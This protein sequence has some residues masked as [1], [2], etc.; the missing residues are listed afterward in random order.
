MKRI[1]PMQNTVQPYPWGS[2]TAIAEL[3]GRKTPAL[4]PQAELWMGAHP[5]APSLVACEEQWV[6][7]IDLIEKA[8]VDILGES[9]IQ[10]F[11]K[12]LPYLFK[13]LA[14]ARPLS[15][16]A[17]PN[18]A[19]A[20]A[21]FERE[22]RCGLALDAPD[23][24]YRDANHKPECI[25]ALTPFWALNGF[26]PMIDI[27]AYLRA[28]CPHG[29]AAERAALQQLPNAQG[30]AR[31]IK[32]LLSMPPSRKKTV[33]DETRQNAASL[34]ATDKIYTWIETLCRAYP[35]DIGVL[36][37]VFL[38][39]LKLEPGQAMFLHSGEMHAYLYGVG[40]ELM[41]NS[42]NVLR[43][44]LTAKHVDVRELLNI[45][46]F[47]P[48]QVEILSGVRIRP[49]EHA[50]PCPAQEFVLSVIST[51]EDRVYQSPKGRGVEI[52]L[53][54]EGQA[55]LT[56]D[57][58]AEKAVLAKGVS[59]IIPAAVEQYRIQGSAKVYKAAVPVL[60]GG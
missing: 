41:A 47:H 15:I 44:G 25:Y 9:V 3:M 42:D 53:C 2:K 38:N 49:C 24:N 31:F 30:M 33:I 6:S 52:I 28:V 34:S 14:A 22:N 12:R 17:H 36:A 59:M 20:Q 10:K 54:T 60:E 58:T 48:R 23:R 40:I 26:R 39:L 13:V 18:L 57:E 21:G 5:K 11:G 29:L 45:L 32:T 37:P 56:D 8:P 43:G 16:Q 50:Y 55:T 51:K 4:E 1:K 7:L 35:E 27:Q 19:Q 46:D